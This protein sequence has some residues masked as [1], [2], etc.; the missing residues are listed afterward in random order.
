MPS[1][2]VGLRSISAFAAL[3]ALALAVSCR[4]FFVGE[5]LQSITISPTTATV[6][7]GGTTQLHAYG[8]NTDGSQAGDV[9][10]KVTWSSNSGAVTVNDTNQRGLLTGEALSTTA[11][12]ITASY[13]ALTPQTAT[14]S[15]CVEGG[16]DFTILPANNTQVPGGGPFPNN[17]GYTA[18]VS[19]QVN[20][21]TQTVDIT[22]G[23]VW[24]SSDTSVISIANGVDPATVTLNAPQTQTTVTVT[25]TYTCNGVAITQTVQTI[26]T[27]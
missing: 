27:P 20:G 24:T 21:S 12:T 3:V 2:K 6:P 4:G 19:A 7:L 9:T 11:A 14:A 16:T 8:V 26:V 22:S 15:V 13:E 25:G 5:Q 1:T 18:S 23:V 17:G 10:G